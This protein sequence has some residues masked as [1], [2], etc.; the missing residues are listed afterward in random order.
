MCDVDLD[1]ERCAVWEEGPAVMSTET[2][3]GRSH[4]CSCCGATIHR[5]EVYL[6]HSN[7]FEGNWS[8]ERACFACWW[9]REAFAEEHE[10]LRWPP[11]QFD[12]MLWN[13]IID[14]RDRRDPWRPHLAAIYR[15][16][17]MSP[18]GRRIAAR[19]HEAHRVRRGRTSWLFPWGR[20]VA[21]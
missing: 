4:E 2:F 5:G 16:R 6:R 13:C 19:R 14:N 17:R 7:L 15:R 1:G 10:G 11:A 8:R 18:M 20:P 3:K 12:E 21:A 9:S